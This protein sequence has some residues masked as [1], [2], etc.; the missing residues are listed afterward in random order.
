MRTFKLGEVIL[1]VSALKNSPGDVYAAGVE[2]RWEE[3]S[4]QIGWEAM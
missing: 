2:N 4:V 3:A 1:D